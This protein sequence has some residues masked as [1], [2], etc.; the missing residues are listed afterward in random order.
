MSKKDYNE[1]NKDINQSRQRNIISIIEM[2]C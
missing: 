2:C 1:E